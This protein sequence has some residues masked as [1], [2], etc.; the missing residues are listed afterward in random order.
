MPAYTA[1]DPVTGHVRAVDT[2]NPRAVRAHCA[3]R[4]VIKRLRAR[5]IFDLAEQGIELEVT[6][7]AP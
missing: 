2:V 1:T 4:L 5:E 6:K 7:G 3:K